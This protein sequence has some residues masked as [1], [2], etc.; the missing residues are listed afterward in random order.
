MH[1]TDAKHRLNRR[2]NTGCSEEYAREELVAELGSA[3]AGATLR[4][5]PDF[6]QN[7]AHLDY[8]IKIMKSDSRAILRTTAAAQAAIVWLIARAGYLEGAEPEL[9]PLAGADQ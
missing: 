5:A 8:R 9:D 2:F 6:G 7:A 1:A 3:F 4:L